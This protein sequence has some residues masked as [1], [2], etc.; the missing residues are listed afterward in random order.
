MYRNICQRDDPFQLETEDDDVENSTTS[1]TLSLASL[2]NF[3]ELNGTIWT[4]ANTFQV[5]V[6]SVLMLLTLLGNAIVIITIIS[7]AELRKKRVNIFILSLSVG[8]LIVCFISMPFHILL[9]VFGQWI[10]GPIACKLTGY[11]YLASV[12]F[13]TFLLTSM[14]IDRYQVRVRLI[15]LWQLSICLLN[16]GNTVSSVAVT[17]ESTILRQ[18]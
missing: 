9:V 16:I 4:K 13:T 12:A 11:C 5:S 6:V 10:L 3:N 7:C 18:S 14:S 17:T 8:D 1:T 15:F 2:D